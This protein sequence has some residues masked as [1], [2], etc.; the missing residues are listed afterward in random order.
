MSF[1]IK[2]RVVLAFLLT[3][4]IGGGAVGIVSMSDGTGDYVG[5]AI[6][7]FVVLLLVTSVFGLPL[8]I[9][10]RYIDWLRWFHAVAA[11]AFCGAFSCLVIGIELMGVGVFAAIGSAMGLLFWLLALYRNPRY[12]HKHHEPT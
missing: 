2:H 12:A 5:D 10:L 4:T 1:L 8:F 7:T 9:M 6:I 11:G 3:P